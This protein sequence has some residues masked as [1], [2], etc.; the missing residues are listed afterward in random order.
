MVPDARRLQYR[1]RVSLA[2]LAF[3][4]LKTKFSIGVSLLS[5]YVIIVIDAHIVC[6][7]S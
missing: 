3:A 6:T 4:K 5:S 1:K 7:N 2:L